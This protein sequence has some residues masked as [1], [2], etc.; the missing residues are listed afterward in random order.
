MEQ[1][2]ETLGN[3]VIPSRYTL[4]FEPD[5]STFQFKGLARIAVHI[6]KKTRRIQLNAKELNLQAAS[7]KSRGPSYDAKVSYNHKNERVILEFPTAVSG[8]VE[9]NIS[10]TGT[11]NDTS[12]GFYRSKYTD[13]GKE[14]YMLASQFEAADARAAFPCFDEP[15]FKALFDVSFA[16]DPELQCL[17][18]MPIKS[19][20]KNGP[21]KVVTFCTSPKMSTYLLYL[22]V[23]RFDFLSEKL[24]PV[25]ISVV[26]VPGKKKYASL[27]LQYGKRFLK[28]YEHY[29]GIKYPLPKLDLIALTDFSAG[30]SAMENWGA[31]TFRES[32]LLADENVSVAKRQRIAE[33]IAH[34]LAHQWFGNLVTMG[35]WNDLWLNESFATM[36][37]FKALDSA[38]PEW[39]MHAQ[40]L[41][42]DV[43]V[44]LSV[45][46]LIATHPISVKVNT[47][48]EIDRFSMR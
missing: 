46:Q 6:A 11:N 45:D 1:R 17:S 13:N 40:Y 4:F 38:F 14:L 18:N 22:S 39:N 31:I 24:G 41:S 42:D 2:H 44:A 43:N 8:E 34:E 12:H 20:S 10:F 21:K 47:P 7:V 28:F 26:T 15:A 29:F 25:K 32:D 35:W 30:S 3:N 33:V 23:G 36:M 9:L 5:L 48:G 27:A 16:V 19:E 37:A